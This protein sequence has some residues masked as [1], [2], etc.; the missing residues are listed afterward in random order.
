MDVQALE[1]GPLATNG[2]VLSAKELGKAA[3]VDAPE[4]IDARIPEI[5]EKTGCR[6]NS[7]LLT[8]GHWDHIMDMKAIRD[9]GATVTAHWKDRTLIE[10]PEVMAAYALPGTRFTPGVVDIWLEGGETLEI[11]GA[12]VEVRH[13]PGHAPGNVLFYF[14][15]QAMAFVGDSLFAGGV[16]RF[17]LPGGDW[18]TL[19]HSIRS[20]IY[21]LPEETRIFPGHGPPTTVGAE[22]RSNPFVRGV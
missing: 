1:L 11:L 6:V 8:H 4:G 21:S 14:P 17:D 13:V 18:N 9:R 2:Y 5:M 10:T 20:R 3:L 19:E 12:Q 16:G 22:K 15:D 7:L